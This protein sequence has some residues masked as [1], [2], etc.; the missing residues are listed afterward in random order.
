MHLPSKNTS[1]N[2]SIIAEFSIVL[3]DLMHSDMTASELFRNVKDTTEDIG[4][5]I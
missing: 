2:E 3:S 4:E 5:F 1:F